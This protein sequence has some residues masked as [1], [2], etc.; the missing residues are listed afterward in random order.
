[1]AVSDQSRDTLPCG[2]KLEALVLQVF[3]GEPPR[4]ASHQADCAHCKA[5]L[6]R[7]GAVRGTIGRL[8]AAPVAA[9]P[10]LVRQVMHRLR[11]DQAAV[12]VAADER[13]M[14]TVSER[15]V[16]QIAVRA[17]LVAPEITFASV[18]L[19]EGIIASP[20]RLSVRLVVAFGPALHDVADG[21]RGC[22]RAAV[23]ELVGVPIGTVDVAIDDFD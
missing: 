9:P 13:G 20:L 23:A 6:E 12:L 17:A 4:D 10:D 15:I 19:T 8:A 1:M 7:L 2:A 16:T 18:Q 21:A 22:I 3:D 14:V 11:G 5:A